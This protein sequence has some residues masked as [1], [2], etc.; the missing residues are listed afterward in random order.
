MT[1][2]LAD[3]TTA[4]SIGLRIKAVRL[5]LGY[6]KAFEFAETYGA[7]PPQHSNYERGHNPPNVWSMITLCERHKGVTLEWIFRGNAD[8]MPYALGKSTL[9]IHEGLTGDDPP[10]PED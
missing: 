5:A 8:S 4:Q 10:E 7:T 3:L 2:A 1:E 6:K 9:E